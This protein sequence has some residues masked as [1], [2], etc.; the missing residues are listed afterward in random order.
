MD[1]DHS[2]EDTEK[3]SHL[4]FPYLK[5]VVALCAICTL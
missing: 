1:T 2:P 4:E 3:E 5:L